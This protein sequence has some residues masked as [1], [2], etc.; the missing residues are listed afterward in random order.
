MRI[1]HALVVAVTVAMAGSMVFAAVA[2]AKKPKAKL[3]LATDNSGKKVSFKCAA[4][5][6]CC[7]AQSTNKAACVKA[8]GICL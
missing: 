1:A 3:C 5:E 2:E 7:W 8:P 4:D 6:K